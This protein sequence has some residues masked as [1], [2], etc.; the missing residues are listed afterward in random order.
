MNLSTYIF[1]RFDKGYTQYPLDCNDQLFQQCVKLSKEDQQLIVFR[2]GKLMFCTFVMYLNDKHTTYVGISLSFSEMM[3]SRYEDFYRLFRESIESLAIEG[4]ILTYN[5]DAI[6]PNCSSF[7]G[8]TPE[9]RQ[10]EKYINTKMEQIL[11]SPQALP[12][13]QYGVSNTSVKY[14]P[15]KVGSES[16]CDFASRYAYTVISD[17]INEQE[18]ISDIEKILYPDGKKKPKSDDSLIHNIK[19]SLWKLLR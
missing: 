9:I 3:I 17:T 19:D 6:V 2:R 1:G 16:I 10:L 13:V 8:K 18:E 15:L 14:C 11:L 4:E 12:P 7:E 5:E